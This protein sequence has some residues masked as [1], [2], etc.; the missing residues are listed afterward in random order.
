[1]EIVRLLDEDISQELRYYEARGIQSSVTGEVVQSLL[2]DI[3]QETLRS[4]ADEYITSRP[5]P[6]E[7]N[8]LLGVIASLSDDVLS[9]VT[10]NVC[11]SSIQEIVEEH[12]ADRELYNAQDVIE[13][14]VLSELMS[15]IASDGIFD[16]SCLD[17][18][19]AVLSSFIRSHDMGL[20]AIAEECLQDEIE[21]VSD[22]R[23]RQDRNA[24]KNTLQRTFGR[25]VVLSHLMLS[26]TNRFDRVLTT[27]FTKGIFYRM[28][29]QRLLHLVEGVEGRAQAVMNSD[30]ESFVFEKVAVPSI[31]DELVNQ[32]VS[33]MLAVEDDI[34]FIEVQ[35]QKLKR[36]N[37]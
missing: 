29:A 32:L 9:E 20:K 13:S 25:Q 4:L 17:A 33:S 21:S 22:F 28:M 30:I 27:H 6:V 34:D 26:M 31:Q 18:Q 7:Y 3:A 35:H 10:Y 5:R 23:R 12:L 16:V 11:K 14:E 19:A 8:P 37:S 36:D 1:M 2:V 24:I 15:V